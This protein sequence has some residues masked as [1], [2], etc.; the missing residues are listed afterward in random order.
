MDKRA[1]IIAGVAGS[2]K[3]SLAQAL[4]QKIA[5]QFIEGDDYHTARAKQKM[6]SGKPLDDD[7]RAPWLSK[8][9]QIMQAQAPAVLACS[10]LKQC[11]RERLSQNLDAQ[12]LWLDIERDLAYQRV[13]TRTNHYMPGS[14]VDSQFATAEPPL[15]GMILDASKPLQELAEVALGK[16]GDFIH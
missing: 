11:Y 13:T 16:L 5:W 4:A 1:I 7:D 15:T 8:L 9:N 6:A 10:A 2:G 12:F 14:L 3:S